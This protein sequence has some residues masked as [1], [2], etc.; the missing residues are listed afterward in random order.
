MLYNGLFTLACS[1][2]FSQKNERVSNNIELCCCL[3]FHFSSN[4]DQNIPFYIQ[5]KHTFMTMIN[6][7]SKVDYYS[8][9][10]YKNIIWCRTTFQVGWYL[11]TCQFVN[12]S[13]MNVGCNVCNFSATIALLLQWWCMLLKITGWF[14]FYFRGQLSD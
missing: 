7:Q 6:W 4:N 9:D 2:P 8:F 13:M 3:L 11:C 5:P 12:K 14:Q 1:V 10:R